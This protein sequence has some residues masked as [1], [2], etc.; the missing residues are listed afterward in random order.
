MGRRPRIALLL[1]TGVLFLT[2]RRRAGLQVR[3]PTTQTGTTVFARFNWRRPDILNFSAIA[4]E[5]H[6][7][8]DH[9]VRFHGRYWGADSIDQR[10]T[11]LILR[12]EEVCHGD[13][14][15]LVHGSAEGRAVGAMEERAKR[16]GHLAGAGKEEQDWR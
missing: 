4:A 11:L 15:D 14:T 7:A 9:P 2:L 8:T 10:N 3:T 12:G 1:E 6:V 16:R 13:V 5:W